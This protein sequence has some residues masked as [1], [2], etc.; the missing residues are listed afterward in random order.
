[1]ICGGLPFP[2]VCYVDLC[3]CKWSAKAKI[4]VFAGHANL[5]V[6]VYLNN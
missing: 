5:Y 2:V 1:M 6:N 3:A 4:P